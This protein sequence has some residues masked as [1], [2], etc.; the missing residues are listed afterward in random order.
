MSDLRQKLE[1]VLGCVEADLECFWE[2]SRFINRA[3]NDERSHAQDIRL[4]HDWLRT[5][6]DH[7][8]ADAEMD[9]R[10]E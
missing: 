5:N 10:D 4:G 7:I 8:I 2:T 1:A 6:L 3:D 9:Q